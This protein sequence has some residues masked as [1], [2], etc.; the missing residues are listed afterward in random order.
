MDNTMSNN[1]NKDDLNI[2]VAVTKEDNGVLI[3]VP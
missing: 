1:F 3:D 2:V